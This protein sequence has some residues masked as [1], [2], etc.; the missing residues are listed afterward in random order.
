MVVVV[1]IITEVFIQDPAIVSVE[2]GAVMDQMLTTAST[3]PTS[4]WA[5]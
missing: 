2:T 4:A 5:A 1:G 3:V